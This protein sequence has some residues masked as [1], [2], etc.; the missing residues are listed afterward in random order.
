MAIILGIKGGK[1][2]HN[3]SVALLDTEKDDILFV[4][5]EERFNG[6]K[7]T[8]C[9]PIGSL[10]YAFKNLNIKYKD[11]DYIAIGNNDNE[12]MSGYWDLFHSLGKDEQFQPMK[13]SCFNQ[14][15]YASMIKM[16]LKTMFPNADIFSI[17]H[18]DTHSALAFYCSPF[19]EAAIFTSDGLGEAEAMTFSYGIKHNL[20]RL[21]SIGYPNS[22]GFMYTL[23]CHLL[24]F[25]GPNPEGK[26]MALAS[27]GKPKFLDSF[28]KIYSSPRSFTFEYNQDLMT[29]TSDGGPP[30]FKSSAIYKSLF[31]GTSARERDEDLKE[32]H[33]DIA[34]SLQCFFEEMVIKLTNDLQEQTKSENICVGGGSFLN[35]VVNNKILDH[36]KFKKIYVNPASHDGGNALGAA[37]YLKHKILKNNNKTKFGTYLGYNITEHEAESRLIHFEIEYTE[38]AEL[39]KEVAR[40]LHEGAVVGW[41]KGKAEIG[42]RA[43]CNRSILVNP[44]KK[45]TID[46]LNKEIKRREWFRPYAPVVME[47]H[48][49]KYFEF[50]NGE[51]NSP[52]MLKVHNILKDAIGK[53]PA[54]SHVDGTAR[55]QTVNKEQNAEIYDLLNEYSKLSGLHV[56][57]NTSFNIGG[58]SI[59]N[60]EQEAIFCF[61]MAKLDYLVLDKFLISKEKNLEAINEFLTNTTLQQ[62]FHSRKKIYVDEHTDFIRENKEIFSGDLKNVE[63]GKL[64]F[65]EMRWS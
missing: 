12:I 41:V 4:G 47:E 24:G 35:S 29:L 55:T 46:Y 15:Y 54:I 60:N 14:I 44:T 58:E 27:F 25:H 53:I 3:S 10:V 38:P 34:A 13:E 64:I 19:E 37:L 16:R 48:A 8:D 65:R 62:Y 28:R 5:E 45:E 36:T 63:D 40:L 1:G 42:P 22:L 33:Y 21:H 31:S 52:Y 23:F 26:V 49:H 20:H 30:S 11:V 59:I 9:F 61:V 50:K 43:L 7:H 51:T 6:N 39:N 2:L 18:H 57:L 17:N 56:L 32:I